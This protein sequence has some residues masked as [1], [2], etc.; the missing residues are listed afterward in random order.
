[1]RRTAC[2]RLCGRGLRSVLLWNCQTMAWNRQL[3]CGAAA[4]SVARH[5][6]RKDGIGCQAMNMCA[7]SSR[8]DSAPIGP[9]YRSPQGLPWPK[10]FRG[11]T[12]CERAN[13]AQEV[14]KLL[15]CHS[16]CCPS[17]CADEEVQAHALHLHMHS[18]SFRQ[19]RVPCSQEDVHMI[20]KPQQSAQ[21][22]SRRST[23]L[24]ALT[25]GADHDADHPPLQQQT[26]A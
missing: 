16:L 13:K 21:T 24:N 17:P 15:T 7:T 8:A 5:V 10:H 23:A 22:A 18:T 20:S 12:A 11:D 26:C 9:Y 2:R 4:V 14:E 6:V 3:Q 19:R 25:P 1:M